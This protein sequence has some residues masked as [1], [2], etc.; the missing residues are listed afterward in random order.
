M[1]TLR[2][3]FLASALALGS[4]FSGA[5]ATSGRGF[6]QPGKV[7]ATALDSMV[8]VGADGV[9]EARAANENPW[10]FTEKGLTPKQVSIEYKSL[11][12]KS[13]P[14]SARRAD[15]KYLK[16]NGINPHEVKSDYLGKGADISLYDLYLTKEG[17]VVI[18]GRHGKGEGIP[19]SYWI[20]KK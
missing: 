18:Y 19:T 9:R 14:F 17:Q 5:T 3:L 13:K 10:A 6:S 16:Q 8:S 2:I 15:E 12:A 1:K 4:C 11:G 7:P 20:P